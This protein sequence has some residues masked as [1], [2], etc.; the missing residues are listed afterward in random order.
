MQGQTTAAA[1]ADTPVV[2]LHLG[3]LP[4]IQLSRQGVAAL[5]LETLAEI[6]KVRQC[7]TPFLIM[8]RLC[9]CRRESLLCSRAL[10]VSSVCTLL[11]C[12]ITHASPLPTLNASRHSSAATVGQMLEPGDPPFLAAAYPTPTQ[13]NVQAQI[14][15]AAPVAT[16]QKC[17]TP[18][19][20]YWQDRMFQ[21][22]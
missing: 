16:C 18:A 2:V 22:V 19:L 7:Y 21:S 8:R 4:H 14:A 5:T 20:T 3:K 17:S 1:E 6:W 12:T 15:M 13:A 11:P 9:R 10:S